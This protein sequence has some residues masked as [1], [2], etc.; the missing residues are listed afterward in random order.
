MEK[1]RFV[2]YWLLQMFS[3]SLFPSL[4][5]VQRF[6]F[7]QVLHRLRDAQLVEEFDAKVDDKVMSMFPPVSLL[8]SVIIYAIISYF[9]GFILVVAHESIISKP[10][11]CWKSVLPG[12]S[13]NARVLGGTSY[14]Y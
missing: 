9:L 8:F 11:I 4:W 12:I 5:S 6:L 13:N 3:I 10:S 2:Y 14:C 1:C 7:L